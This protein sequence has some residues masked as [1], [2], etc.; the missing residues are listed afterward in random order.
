ME[1]LVRDCFRKEGYV[2]A[3]KAEA[4][5]A[6]YGHRRIA[7]LASN[8]NPRPPSPKAITRGLEALRQANRYP[9]EQMA[10][11]VDHLQRS[12]GG[13]N[14]V[15]GVG[16]DGVIETTIRTLVGPGDRVAIATPTFSFYRLAAAAASADVIGVPR[17]S[18]FRVDPNSFIHAAREAKCSF[19][20]TPNN[21]TGNATPPEV[22]EEIL[23]E[24]NGLLFLDNA[25]VEFSD[26]DYRPLMKKYENLVIGRT[27]SKVFSL[28]GLRIGYAFVPSWLR[29]YYMRAATPFTLNSVSAAAATGALDDERHFEES[30]AHIRRWRDRYQRECRFPVAPSDANFVM[31]NIDPWTGNSATEVLA[32][33]GVLV[34]SCTSF[35][36]LPDHYIRVSIGEDWENEQFIREINTLH[37]MGG[38]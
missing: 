15:T 29:P 2:F 6:E 20:C 11:L 30:V 7:R 23:E 13:Y 9:D 28:A 19:L 27:M 37:A 33:R 10:A 18:R 17:D 24:I 14:F 34:R 5:A 1:H 38:P 32:T 36:G 4:V 8:E 26:A 3:K 25:Y 22:V 31:V 35:D 21:P 16:M 12:H